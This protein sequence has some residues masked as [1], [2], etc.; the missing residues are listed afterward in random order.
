MAEKNP[1]EIGAMW[2]KTGAKGDYMTGTVNGERVVVFRNDKRGNEKA[3]D[4]RVLK[5]KPREGQ[6]VEAGVPIHEDEIPF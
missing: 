6:Q 3:P 1:D 2:M 4:W 5:A